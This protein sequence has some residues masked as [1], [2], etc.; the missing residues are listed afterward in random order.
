M[1]KRNILERVINLGVTDN[2]TQNDRKLVRLL[3]TICVTWYSVIVFFYI[4][5]Y[6]L[7][8]KYIAV[9]SCHTVQLS[10]LV[11]VQFIQSKKLY[12]TARLLF[13]SVSLLHFFIFSNFVIDGNLVEF[14]YLLIPLFSLLFFNKW[15]Y[16]FG[17]LFLLIIAFTIL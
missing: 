6:F 17:F 16:H 12:F 8:P 10:F 9:I 13:I 1:K 5:G 2:L 11:L 14:Y 3:N 15:Y 4:A 7:E